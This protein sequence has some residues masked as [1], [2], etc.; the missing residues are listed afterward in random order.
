MKQAAEPLTGPSVENA[1]G[2]CPRYMQDFRCIAGRCEASCCT[3]S[4]TIYLDRKRYVRLKEALSHSREDRE[5][6]KRALKR[7]RSKNKNDDTYAFILSENGSCIFHESDGLCAIQRRFGEDYLGRVCRTYPRMIRASGRRL[8]MTGT[9][10][11][12]EVVRLCLFAGSAMDMVN[13]DPWPY[14]EGN[15][16]ALSKGRTDPGDPYLTQQD[17]VRDIALFILGDERIPLQK[18]LFTLLYFAAG[19]SEFLYPR[20]PVFTEDRLSGELARVEDGVYPEIWDR[21]FASLEPPVHLPMTVL[22]ALFVKVYRKTAPAFR[23]LLNTVWHTYARLDPDGRFLQLEIGKGRVSVECSRLLALYQERSARFEETLL[24]ELDH[25]ISRYLQNLVIKESY[26]D[27][28]DLFS[29]AYDLALRTALLRFLVISHPALDP[30][31]APW[32]AAPA[33][34]GRMQDVFEKTVVE[35]FFRFSRGLEH[36][37]RFLPD[38]RESLRDQDMQDLAHAVLV[39]KV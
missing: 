7:N 18:R 6:A 22:Q 13:F 15:R 16:F 19:C 37:K 29:W 4:W 25:C 12:P 38:L 11:C 28:P 3:G 35:V 30:W 8:E 21:N 9:F 31:L 36:N 26:T 33:A 23:N 20:S 14:L 2:L 10:S 34:G 27:Y 32:E 24:P 1:M 5:L 17:T 39:L